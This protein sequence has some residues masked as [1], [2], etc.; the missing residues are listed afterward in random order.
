MVMESVY[1]GRTGKEGTCRVSTGS[2]IG[3]GLFFD[4]NQTSMLEASPVAWSGALWERFDDYDY[5]T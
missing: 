3:S 5:Y 1:S 2:P 4:P